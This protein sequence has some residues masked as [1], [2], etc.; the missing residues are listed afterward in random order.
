VAECREA[1]CKLDLE[2]RPL[3]LLNHELAHGMRFS[4]RLREA[5]LSDKC[6]I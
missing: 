5:G 3:Y 1:S 6:A 4:Q 2:S